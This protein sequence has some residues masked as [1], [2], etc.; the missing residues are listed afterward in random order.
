MD[1]K[2]LGSFLVP[3]VSDLSFGFC[4]GTSGDLPVFHI[5]ASSA[6]VGVGLDR[7]G[8]RPV[9]SMVP[10]VFVT[11]LRD[12][13]CFCIL[14]GSDG[15]MYRDDFCNGVVGWRVDEN[16]TH[17]LHRIKKTS[18]LQCFILFC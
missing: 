18:N 7:R 11:C 9:V 6:V 14:L 13:V 17:C 8:M 1:L 4:P 2:K 3:L 15:F 12:T 16:P 10:I 5:V